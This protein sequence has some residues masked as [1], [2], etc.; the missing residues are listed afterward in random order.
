MTSALAGRYEV[1][2][3]IGR[4]G[5]ATVFLARDVRHDRRVALKVLRP[6]LGAVLGAER[7]LAEIR[8]T[9]NLQHPNLVPVFDSGEAD[10]L[11]FYVMPFIEGESLRAKLLRER[12]LPIADVLRIAAGVA[13][14]LDYAHRHGVVHRDLKPENILLHDGQPLVADSGIALAATRAAGSRITESGISL[15]TPAYMSPEQAT[16]ERDIDGRSDVYALG[17]VVYEMLSG[18]PPHTGPTSQ[19][20]IAR[21]LTEPPRA[22]RP[23]RPTV[24]DRLEA[25]VL[26][27]LQKLPADRFGTAQEFVGAMTAGDADASPRPGVSVVGHPMKP[28]VRR[29][30]AVPTIVLSLCGV[31][32]VAGW[33]A[34]GRAAPRAQTVRFTFTA[35]RGMRVR[36]NFGPLAS[37]SPDGRRIVYVGESPRGTQLWIR[38]LDGVT[39]QALSG[40][41]DA[42]GP[43]FSPDGRSVVFMNSARLVMVQV[44]LDGGP[45]VE[46]YPTGG[47]TGIEWISPDSVVHT[48]GYLAF[49]E[50]LH[51]SAAKGGPLGRFFADDSAH[52]SFAEVSPYLAPDGSTLFFISR[53]ANGRVPDDEIAYAT[54]K[55]RRVVLTGIKARQILGFQEG[56]L[57]YV[58]ADGAI[59][60]VPYNLRQHRVAGARVATNETTQSDQYGPKASLSVHG[61]LVYPGAAELARPV[62]VDAS[63]ATRVLIGDERVYGSPRFSPDGSLIALSIAEGSH[64]DIWIYHVASGSRERLTTEGTDNTRPEWSPDGRRV[65]YRSN[66][67]PQTAIWWKPVDQSG[68]A[69][70]LSPQLNLPVHEGVLTADGHTLIYRV[71]TPDSARNVYAM[72]LIGDRTPRPVLAT[73]FDEYTARPSPGDA[74]WLV[75]VSNESSRSEVYVRPFPGPGGRTQISDGGGQEPL[76]S[77]DGR[78]VYYRTPQAL[79]V[80]TLSMRG[81]NVSVVKRDVVLQGDYLINRFHPQYDV[82]P[83]GRSFLM[84]N[85]SNPDVQLTVVLNWI[86]GL[87]ERLHR[88]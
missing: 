83:N 50:R 13:S 19:A 76:W 17:A 14:A 47:P 39:A 2:R 42:Q 3:E 20:T 24:P 66:Q 61:D 63:G 54:L 79:M 68:R 64:S 67:G 38:D 73:L 44:P 31:A 37:I 87:K 62:L 48:R 84:I 65:L 75:Y 35:P 58:D 5:M 77:A 4:G 7:F 52:G 33:F 46:L 30:W 12:Q 6:E 88:R 21:L 70:Q 59:F 81:D 15:G 36:N 40:T 57:I 34:H 55:E 51:V 41:E 27:A 1:Q 16:G 78:R 74:K 22:L 23:S 8:V 69:E 71:D 86:A 29:R 10:T 18:E 53:G 49:G 9:A 11:L 45:P 56:H 72:S 80:A 25:A 28:W 43:L 60:A 85:P 32:A 26:T 82:A